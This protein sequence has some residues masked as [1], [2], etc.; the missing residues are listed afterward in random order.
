VYEISDLETLQYQGGEWYYNKYYDPYQP[1]LVVSGR[2]PTQMWFGKKPRLD[3]V[4][5]YRFIFESD[6]EQY[7]LNKNI[8]LTKN[9]CNTFVSWMSWKYEWDVDLPYVGFKQPEYWEK[10]LDKPV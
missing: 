4:Y 6:I 3:A 2:D 7:P 1:Q 5:P 9:N 8:T 10:L